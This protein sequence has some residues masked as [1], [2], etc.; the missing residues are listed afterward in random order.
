[1]VYIRGTEDDKSDWWNMDTSLKTS[2]P[3]SGR[4]GVLVNAHYDSVS[5]GY[6]ATDDGVGMVTVLQL[7]S[8]FT[9]PGNR[10]AR[11]IVAL[12]NNGEE[13]YL[14]G[15]RAFA[16]HPISQFPHTFLNLEG[17]GAGGRA[18]MFRST[19]TEVTK[20]YKKS[21][22][23]FA[24]VVSRDGFERGLIRSQTDYV[25]FNGELGLRGLDV[26]FFEPRSRYHTTE[27][28]AR[29]TSVN[30]LWHMLSAAIATTEGLASDTSSEFDGEGSVRKGRVNAGH[31]TDAVWF[32]IFGRAFTVFRLHTLFALS[33]T[34]LVVTPMLLIALSFILSRVDKYYLFS[35]KKYVHSSD[36]D[37]PVYLNGWRG[38]FRMMLTA[39]FS[40]TWFILRGADAMRPSALFRTYSLIW[41]YIGA[42]LILIAV[43]V[44][45]N[46]FQ[47]AGGYFMVIYFAAIF[48][49]L[50]ISYLELFALPK[51]SVYVQQQAMIDEAN[52]PINLATPPARDTGSIRSNRPITSSSAH[53][54]PR[55]E[56][57]TDEE[58][59]DATETTSLLRG[60]PNQ[61]FARYGDHRQ[62]VDEGT[63]QE[64][65]AQEE[66]TLPPPYG[67]EQAWSGYLP[68]WTWLFQF[69]LLAPI[70]LILVGQTGLLLTSALYQTPA[71]GSPALPIY[72]AI[73]VFSILLLAPLG[74]FIHRFGYQIPTFLFLLFIGTV[75]YNLMAFPFSPNARLKVYFVQ[76]V[77]LDTGVNTVSLTGLE[78]YVRDIVAQIPSAA[79]QEITC[80]APDYGAREGLSKC[81]WEGIAPRVVPP[82][83]PEIPPE[84]GYQDWL[85]YNI[86]RVENATEAVISLK[87]KNTRACR[88]YF[89]K[90]IEDLHVEG[91]AAPD[92]THKPVGENGSTEVRLWSREWGR[93]WNV[94]VK[95]KAE[96]KAD[97][98]AG[99][100]NGEGMDGR[101]VCLW[102]DAN[103][104][105]VVPALEEVRM[106]MPSWA[107][108]SKLGDGL[109][110]GSKRFAA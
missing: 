15:A 5:T 32:D 23:P 67:E 57:R 47:I 3:N 101:V 17:A 42:Y 33:V 55:D 6:G 34:L 73:A 48:A 90:P 88:L 52:Q 53:Q 66:P 16:Q 19:D 89:D 58:A 72:L 49:A 61:S 96:E 56:P 37:E 22:Y 71:D 10:P 74:P 38:F 94:H 11:G 9:S 85:S 97:A 92:A 59:E 91:S 62:S 99:D 69:L 93:G 41:M 4:G 2:R 8:Y 63:E 18:A 20:F 46:M 31:G 21:P 103:E 102:S 28:S 12:L 83:H 51:K 36:D 50:L 84:K 104:S 100:G 30:S 54:K 106:F 70:V 75:V 65:I 86:S 68:R 60:D 110:E 107:Q 81:M 25:V 76:Q 24:N 14:N 13:D 45:E 44:G 105:G 26:A 1:M 80:T 64:L 39:W 78:S 109:V 40:V 29:E 43:T 108:V 82:A 7:I 27:D 77:D 95:W 35:R 79:G 87:G 98:D